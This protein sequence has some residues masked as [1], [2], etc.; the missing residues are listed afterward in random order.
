MAVVSKENPMFSCPSLR[1]LRCM[2][3]AVA[4]A[5][6]SLTAIAQGLGP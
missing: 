2:F 3:L 6:M 5:T 4:A 1:T